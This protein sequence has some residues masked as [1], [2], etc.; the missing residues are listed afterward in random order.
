MSAWLLI[1]LFTD[2]NVDAKVAVFETE[3]ECRTMEQVT[4]E[5]IGK[6]KG[7]KSVE[8]MRGELH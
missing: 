3:K 7:V 8:C 4:K 6:R 5:V 1:V 2:P